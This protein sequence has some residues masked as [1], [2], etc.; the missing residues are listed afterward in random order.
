[1]DEATKFKRSKFFETKGGIIKDLPKYLHGKSM[2]GNPIKILRQDNAKE[3]VAAI[4]MARGKDWKL[5]FKAEFTARTPQ[6]NLIA[7]SAFTVIATQVQSMMNAAQ[8]P[9]ELR[10]KSWA[11]TVMTATYLNNS[12][13]ATINGEKKT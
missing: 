12:V 11:E 2:R 9:N 5:G 13:I 4:K 6:Q 7:E 1:M 10:F 8:L 3:N